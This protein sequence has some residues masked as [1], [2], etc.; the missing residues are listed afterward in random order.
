MC[1][2]WRISRVFLDVFPVLQYREYALNVTQWNYLEIFLSPFTAKPLYPQEVVYINKRCYLGTMLNRD[3]IRSLPDVV[4]GSVVGP[5]KQNIMRLCMQHLVSSS[6]SPKQVLE[7]FSR[8]FYQS[9]K[10][11]YKWPYIEV[12]VNK[13]YALDYFYWMVLDFASVIGLCVTFSADQ[14]KKKPIA[15]RWYTYFPAFCAGCLVLFSLRLVSQPLQWST[16]CLRIWKKKGSEPFF[17]LYIYICW[18][19]WE[20]CIPINRL[21]R[22]FIPGSCSL[23]ARFVSRPRVRTVSDSCDVFE[24]WIRPSIFSR[25][26]SESVKSWVAAQSSSVPLGIPWDAVTKPAAWKVSDMYGNIFFAEICRIYFSGFPEAREERPSRASRY[27]H[28]TPSQLLRQLF[29][30]LRNILSIK[31]QIG[32]L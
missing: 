12:F 7:L 32:H 18:R 27:F 9:K 17:F 1:F 26:W 2:W 22:C 4:R 5:E 14:K 24:S 6:V 20:D 30:L 28:K 29:A 11:R 16:R 21:L 13:K 15:I 3:L 8:E 10:N 23:E 25:F 31:K 19:F